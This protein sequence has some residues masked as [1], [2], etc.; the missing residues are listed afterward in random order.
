M[1]EIHDVI[2]AFADGEP[3]DPEHLE[4]ALAQPEGRTYLIDLLALRGLF[5]R[6]AAWPTAAEAPAARPFARRVL[7]ISA[8]AA[9]VVAAA[10]GGYVTGRRSPAA[11]PPAPDAGPVT[12]RI[13]VTV[14]APPPTQVIRFEPGVDWKEGGGGN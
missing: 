12:A 7:R 14:T 10:L 4:Q 9:F 11:P 8:A 5:G 13:E 1:P 6:R 3:V 2:A